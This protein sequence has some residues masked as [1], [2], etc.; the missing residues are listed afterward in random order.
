[1]LAKTGCGMTAVSGVSV[2][3]K[4]PF[5]FGCW[6]SGE[7]AE[8][9][10][11]IGAG[12]FELLAAQLSA[13]RAAEPQSLLDCLRHFLAP[14]VWKPAHRAWAGHEAIRWKAQPG[15]LRIVDVA[16]HLTMMQTQVRTIGSHIPRK[17]SM[18]R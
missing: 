8:H 13:P 15:P 3:I 4:A 18:A 10:G 5:V 16:W 7:L 1:M 17:D 14:Q 12:A 9:V 11:D 2:S 6:M